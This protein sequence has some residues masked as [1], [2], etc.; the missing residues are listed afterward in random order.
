MTLY[1]ITVN[2]AKF[3]MINQAIQRYLNYKIFAIY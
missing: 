2:S 1:H 3:H